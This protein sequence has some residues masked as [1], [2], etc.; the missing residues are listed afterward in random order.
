MQIHIHGQKDA[1][2]PVKI[3]GIDATTLH[4]TGMTISCVSYACHMRLEHLLPLK[5]CTQNV[6]TFSY[7]V[8]LCP[9]GLVCH[10]IMISNLQ[11]RHTFITC[12]N[13]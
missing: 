13:L 5:K 6:S 10:G 9:I 8:Y 1:N 12:K 11:F 2:F 3:V 7:W 4:D